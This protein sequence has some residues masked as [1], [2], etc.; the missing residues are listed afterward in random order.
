MLGSPRTWLWLERGPA[1]LVRDRGCVARGRRR[2][3]RPA[4]ERRRVRRPHAGRSRRGEPFVL[5]PGTVELVPIGEDPLAVAPVVLPSGPDRL[6]RRRRARGDSRSRS[7]ACSPGSPTRRASL[8]TSLASRSLALRFAGEPRFPRGPP[9]CGRRRGLT[10]PRSRREAW[11]TRRRVGSAAAT[12]AMSGAATLLQQS[13]SP[14]RP[15]GA[16]RA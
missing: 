10:P 7:S 9:P 6:H 13:R 14:Y 8:C 5:E 1:G 15:N 16:R 11:V 12:P 4:R 2:A 3:D